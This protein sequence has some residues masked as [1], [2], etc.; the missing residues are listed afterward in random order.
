MPPISKNIMLWIGI[1][2]AGL[3]VVSLLQN[4]MNGQ[5]SNGKSVERLAY[6][7]FLNKVESGEVTDVV[8]KESAESGTKI[9]GH[10]NNGTP[11][12]LQAV[13]D[14]QLVE[15]LRS[16]NVKMAA[17]SSNSG[18]RDRWLGRLRASID[19]ATSGCASSV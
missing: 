16:H 10:F 5:S 9:Q 7:E 14:P 11:F 12:A 3:L 13:N 8:I 18:K 2:L 17:S 4:D 6:S 19:T 15:R 1:M